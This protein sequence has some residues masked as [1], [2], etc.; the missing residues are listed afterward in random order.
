M[1]CVSH[2]V[3]AEGG[4]GGGGIYGGGGARGSGGCGDGSEDVDSGGGDSC[5]GWSSGDG[6]GRVVMGDALVGDNLNRPA[7]LIVEY[8]IRGLLY[9]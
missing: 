2:G 1:V 5:E 7:V 6:N 3:V 4:S 8:D 9:N